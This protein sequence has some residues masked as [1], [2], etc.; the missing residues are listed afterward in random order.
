MTALAESPKLA[1]ASQPEGSSKCIDASVERICVGLDVRDVPGKGL[2]MVAIKDIERGAQ[3]LQDPMVL[4]IHVMTDSIEDPLTG[5]RR[6]WSPPEIEEHLRG[7]LGRRSAED[8]SLFWQLSDC[9]ANGTEKTVAGVVRTNAL[10]AQS[11]QVPLCAG[12]FPMAARL[13]HSCS[14]NAYVTFKEELGAVVVCAVSDIPAESEVCISYVPPCLLRE[15]RRQELEDFGFSCRCLACIADGDALQQ[16][17]ANRGRIQALTNWLYDC[18]AGLVQFS[19]EM[20]QEAVDEALVLIKLELDG[21]P[22]AREELLRGVPASCQK[23]LR[24]SS[25]P[26]K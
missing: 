23:L 9:H 13:N 26:R 14:P 3:I 1:E 22:P 12:V 20:V 16:S 8:Q 5:E 15:Q 19:E 17:D 2:G 7:R 24:L 10:P 4:D 11:R 21:F 18:S 25:E 6:P